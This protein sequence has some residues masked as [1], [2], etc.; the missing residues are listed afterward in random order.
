M[1]QTH[2]TT[3]SPTLPGGCRVLMRGSSSPARLS[4]VSDTTKSMENENE[5]RAELVRYIK[6]L[7]ASV[8]S[9]LDED[10]HLT[11]VDC[12]RILSHPPDIDS[13][14]SDWIPRSMHDWAAKRTAFRRALRWAYT[15][16]D[17]D[18]QAAIEEGMR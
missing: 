5:A 13:V 8:Q 1:T 6:P 14:V 2:D 9:L 3:L 11:R 17:A 7:I 15:A 12:N 18:L 4:S 10:P 16:S